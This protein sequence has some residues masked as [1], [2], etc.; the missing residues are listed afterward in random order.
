MTRLWT[1]LSHVSLHDLYQVDAGRQER[2]L[3]CRQV[4]RASVDRVSR[5]VGIFRTDADLQKAVD[6]LGALK[7]EVAKVRVTGSAAGLSSRSLAR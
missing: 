5:T 6:E 1:A 4:L 7:A 3:T 2:S